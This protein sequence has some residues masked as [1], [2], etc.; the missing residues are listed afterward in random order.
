M[1]V[2]TAIQVLVLETLGDSYLRFT[3]A[4]RIF[5]ET[6]VHLAFDHTPEPV[7]RDIC[8][9]YQ[10]LPECCQNDCFDE[11]IM[12]AWPSAEAMQCEGCKRFIT[13]WSSH[14]LLCTRV[15]ECAHRN[16]ETVVRSKGV[17]KPSNF[18]TMANASTLNR[19]SVLHSDALAIKSHKNKFKLRHH[20]AVKQIARQV[21]RQTS[22]T[23]RKD[24]TGIG[25]NPKFRVL[26]AERS[27]LSSMNLSKE[28]FDAAIKRKADEYDSSEL[29]QVPPICVCS[30][31][32]TFAAILPAC[33]SKYTAVVR[34]IVCNS[35]K[36]LCVL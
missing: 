19:L 21:Q 9:A 6:L 2:A 25:G 33:G 13:A 23:K 8:N 27:R 10:A 14:E 20:P 15:V 11:L 26:N 16:N 4:W 7:K 28:E 3:V 24:T 1:A 31:R 34:R 35:D 30:F 29:A 17:A 12:S 5:P 18:R 32:R 36:L 22:G